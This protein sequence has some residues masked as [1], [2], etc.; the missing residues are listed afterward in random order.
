VARASILRE[1]QT[2]SDVQP[3]AQNAGA[4]LFDSRSTKSASLPKRSQYA[5]SKMRAASQDAVCAFE[6]GGAALEDGQGG[7]LTPEGDNRRWAAALTRPRAKREG[8]LSCAE[9]DR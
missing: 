9:Y 8:T 5:P 6:D 3:E 7:L 4:Q 2:I 1:R